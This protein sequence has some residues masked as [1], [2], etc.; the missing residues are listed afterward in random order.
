M[1]KEKSNI[2]EKLKEIGNSNINTDDVKELY[3]IPILKAKVSS[4]LG[5]ILVLFPLLFLLGAFL[6]MYLKVEGSVFSQLYIWV[7]EKA[8]DSDSSLVSWIIRFLLVIAPMFALAINL[9]AII[10]V[11]HNK[12]QRELILTVKLKWISIVL[13]LISF[14]I[15]FTF[16]LYGVAENL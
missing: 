12:K 13:I 1:K 7:T 5:I 2:E 11:F 14:L 15:V 6:E 8:P 4:R 3:K 9:F 10:N 16:L